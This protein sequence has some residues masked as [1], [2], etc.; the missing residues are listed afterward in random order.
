MST[1]SWRVVALSVVLTLAL[2]GCGG[3]IGSKSGQSQM[4]A[5]PS[6]SA[7]SDVAGTIAFGGFERTYLLHL[8]PASTRLNPTPLVVALHGWPMTAEQM[9]AITHLATAGDVHGF[10]VV[11]PQGY[12]RSWSVPGG[13][14]TPARNAGID[15]VA[16]VR[17]LIDSIEVRYGL[18]ARRVVATG[19]SNG[20]YLTQALG[21][22]LSDRLIGIVPVAAP[23]LTRPASQCNPATPLSVLEMVG[24]D[25]QEAATFGDT[26]SFW[27]RADECSEPAV[28]GSLPDVAHDQT[29]VTTISFTRCSGGTEV[30]GYLVHGGGHAWPGGEPLGSTEDFGITTMQFKAS[31]L[32]WAFLNHHM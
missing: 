2:L 25:D 30:T 14:N 11:F 6:A 13:A 9:K 22:A 23:L 32:I 16:F 29:S 28:A 1:P 3:E 21:C 10:A 15:D 20:G 4:P 26:L 8:P 17:A 5:T 18:D 31:D 12:L 27:A 24:T 19:I 7:G